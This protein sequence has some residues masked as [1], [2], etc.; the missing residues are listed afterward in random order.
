MR[1]RD[2]LG[3]TDRRQR[4]FVR[5]MQVVLI[6][7]VFVGFDRGDLR[8]VVNAGVALGVTYVPAL[9]ERDYH[10]SLDAGLTLWI[11]LA[12]FLHAI[13]TTGIPG[14]SRGLYDTF[15]WWDNLTHALSASVVAAAG[16]AT[17]RAF[18]AHSE[19]VYLPPRFTFLFVVLFVMAFG[20]LWEVLEFGI[21]G[22]A[23]TFGVQEV[24]IQHGIDDSM[25]DLLFDAVGAVIVG[26]WGQ[27]HTRLD[28][29]V[30]SIVG[31]TQTRRG[32]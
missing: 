17:A 19:A 25:T 9:L 16:Y 20:V 8:I 21:G 6:G 11:T 22:A 23:S 28:E 29:V 7:L 24:L 30:D 1:I 15:W 12:V 2:Y 32:S 27:I 3:I 18:D 4:Q 10:I 31:N 13:G 26:T 5:V 14:L